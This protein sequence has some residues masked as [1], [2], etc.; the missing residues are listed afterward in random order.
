MKEADLTNAEYIG[1][2]AFIKD[3]LTKF[4]VTLGAALKELGDNPFAFCDTGAFCLEDVFTFNGNDYTSPNYNYAISDAVQVIEGSLYQS[5]PNGLELVTFAFGADKFTVADKTVRISA[6]AFAASDVAQ[7]KLPYTVYSIGHKAFYDCDELE[8]VA[9]TSYNAPIL[10]EEY[11][12]AYYVSGESLAAT[13]DYTIIGADGKTETTHTGLGIVP[14]FMWNAVETPSCVYY[15][16][17]FM[18]YIGHVEEPILMVRP[19][20]GKNYDSF[21][22]SQYFSSVV[23]GA[24]AADPTTVKAIDAINALPESV[25]LSDKALVT[26]ARRLYDLISTLEQ[27]ALVTNYTTLTQAEKRISDLEYLEENNGTDIPSDTTEPGNESGPAGFIVLA[28]AVVIAVLTP[29]LFLLQ[30]KKKTSSAETPC[31]TEPSE[32]QNEENT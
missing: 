23:D 2:F 29:I 20:N 6:M 22:F 7:V 3:Q 17:S 32:D 21:I 24:A 28:V 15:G 5:V 10:E 14:Y 4:D 16:A 1:Q 30:K 8:F 12:F 25:S 27:K 19:V 13:G 9:F 31:E 11:D 18:D 26:E